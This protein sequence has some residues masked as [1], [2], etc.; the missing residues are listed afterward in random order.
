[1]EAVRL[2][3]EAVGVEVGGVGL[4]E[5]D[6][7]EVLEAA[8]ERERLLLA[9]PVKLLLETAEEDWAAEAEACGCPESTEL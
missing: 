7:E 9:L 4:A 8:T 5:P 2:A 1:M 3:Q 6:L